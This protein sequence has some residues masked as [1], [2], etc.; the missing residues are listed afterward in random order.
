MANDP[1][2]SS[3]VHDQRSTGRLANVTAAASSAV[4]RHAVEMLIRL[5][6]DHSAR[7]VQVGGDRLTGDVG[8]GQRHQQGGAHRPCPGRHRSDPQRAVAV[9]VEDAVVLRRNQ[10]RRQQERPDGHHGGDLTG[11]PDERQ[12]N[13]GHRTGIG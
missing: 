8:N 10:K 1:T 2:S 5:A 9:D 7:R 12:A 11:G 13:R 3:G 4:H 6:S